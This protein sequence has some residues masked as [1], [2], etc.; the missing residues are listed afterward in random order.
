MDEELWLDYYYRNKEK[1]DP[2]PDQD[3]DLEPEID[4][5]KEAEPEQSREEAKY[6]EKEDL[7]NKV[8]IEI[9]PRQVQEK[10]N[11]H[12]EHHERKRWGRE[13]DRR[14]RITNRSYQRLQQT[15]PLQRKEVPRRLSPVNQIIQ[16]AITNI[17]NL[18]NPNQRKKSIYFGR[19]Y[20]LK[21]KDKLAPS[22][23]AKYEREAKTLRSLKE[24]YSNEEMF[25]YI[26]NLA[27]NKSRSTYF[28]QKAILERILS[29]QE[30]AGD[31]S[32]IGLLRML[33]HMPDYHRIRHIFNQ[34]IEKSRETD[35]RRNCKIGMDA[36]LDYMCEVKSPKHP[37]MQLVPL[38]LYHTGARVSE[39]QGMK[40]YAEP[41]NSL[42]IRIK[43]MKTGCARSA[44]A[45]RT[46]KIKDKQICALLKSNHIGTT[47][48]DPFVGIPTQTIRNNL[49]AA[50]RRLSR[51]GID[52]PS[53]HYF[54][55]NFASMERAA[56]V[57][58]EQL[59]KELGHTNQETTRQ[60]GGG[61][62]RHSH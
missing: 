59:R 40:I 8:Q 10:Q 49:L 55:H 53:P 46:V 7:E 31:R 6:Q 35:K 32:G 56:G 21:A 23:A 16:L 33:R 42:T 2:E 26:I 38:I 25:T 4:Q 20:E 62:I 60:Y 11:Q 17:R 24:Q 57:D 29:D 14:S 51:R 41:D 48:T 45:T 3:N 12:Q 58:N 50:R 18:E 37:M 15:P 9:E 30:A 13:H 52:V 19:T 54:R 34:K 1:E 44:P 61:N 36:V 28:R 39:V 22:T 27:V 43:S 47:I 5:E